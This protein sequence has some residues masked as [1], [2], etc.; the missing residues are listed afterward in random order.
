[1]RLVLWVVVCALAGCKAGEGEPCKGE[2]AGSL[3]CHDGHCRDPQTFCKGDERCARDG[4][5]SLVEG[6]CAASTQAECDASQR[7]KEHGHCKFE[8]GCCSRDGL[9]RSPEEDPITHA[10]RLADPARRKAALDKLEVLYRSELVRDGGDRHGKHVRAIAADIARP[11]A[12]LVADASVPAAERTAA[13]L[14][15]AKGRHEDAAPALVAAVRDYRPGS[16]FDPAMPEVLSA[17]AELRPEEAREPVL[18]LFESLE[19]GTRPGEQL[20]H[21]L[22]NAVAAL[23]HPGWEAALVKRLERPMAPQADTKAWQNERHWQRT[24]ARALGRLGSKK[25]IEALTA[26]VLSPSK[27]DIAAEA[28][29]ALV[30]I[31]K[32]AADTASAVLRGEHAALVTYAKEQHKAALEAEV[33]ELDVPIA[34]ADKYRTAA[35]AVVLAHIGRSDAIPLVLGALDKSDAVGQARITLALVHLPHEPKVLDAFKKAYGSLPLDVPISREDA[36]IDVLAERAPFFFQNAWVPWLVDRAVGWKGTD[37]DL[38]PFRDAAL[39]AAISLM[40]A[41]QS[42]DID[43]LTALVS[44]D[45]YEKD[46]AAAKTLV[47]SCK[48]LG[49]YLD[50]ARKAEDAAGARKAAVMAGTLAKES[51]RRALAEAIVKSRSPVAR[52]ILAAALDHLLPGGDAALATELQRRLS[53]AGRFDETPLVEIVGRLR[54]RAQ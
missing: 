21:P 17:I 11:L 41:D 40:K 39:A 9:C 10:F 28:I 12:R 33:V 4:L 22:S 48:E 26:V 31:G 34:D 19:V 18:A 16:D 47:S 14:L 8:H 23:A 20:A 54:A 27:E 15:L 45:K 49:C 37:T 32:P 13:L 38:A 35:A 43:R 3:V 29:E 53:D 2:C 36:G 1:V 52:R 5:C 30:L 51:D 25:A 44:A 7:C 24:A 6:A 46:Y 42:A 50:A